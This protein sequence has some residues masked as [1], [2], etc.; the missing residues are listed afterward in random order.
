MTPTPIPSDYG[1]AQVELDVTINSSLERVWKALVEETSEW[2][3]REFFTSPGTKGFIIE[4]R[5][6]GRVY[7]DWGA[8]A[9]LLWFTVIGL[10][11]PTTLMLLGHLTPAFG[12]P[13]MSV[14]ELTLQS[15]GESVV[16]RVSETVSGRAEPSMEA[17]LRD[18]WL[19]IFDAGLRAFVESRS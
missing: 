2:W 6:G 19:A 7:E 15:V 11:P 9:G 3:P 5:L 17:T 12:G 10:N 18:G 14:L 4:P 8:G 16:L 1:I 13:A